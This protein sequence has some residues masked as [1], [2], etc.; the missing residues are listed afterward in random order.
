MMSKHNDIPQQ[1]V[2]LQ[3][4]LEIAKDNWLEGKP[5]DAVNLLQRAK[6][7]IGL[8]IWRAVPLKQENNDERK[9]I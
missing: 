6:R 1:I 4:L 7:E 5:Q 2:D 8:V 9:L 3:T